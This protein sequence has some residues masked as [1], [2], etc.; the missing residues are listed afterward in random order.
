MIPRSSRKLDN[1]IDWHHSRQLLLPIERK[2]ADRWAY[3]RLKDHAECDNRLTSQVVYT[4]RQLRQ[5]ACR[6]P[7]EAIQPAIQELSRFL[8]A[9]L[10]HR[11]GTAAKQWSAVVGSGRQ[12]SAVVGVGRQKWD[13]PFRSMSVIF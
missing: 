2:H 9:P 13:C 7:E 5:F 10:G 12:W 11:S 1:K 6:C 3:D 8:R 4:T